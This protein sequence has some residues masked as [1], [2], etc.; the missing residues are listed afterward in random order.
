MNRSVALRA[1]CPARWRGSWP[2]VVGGTMV[3][4]GICL[5]A[6]VL[7]SE[8]SE[9]QGRPRLALYE[10]PDG[11]VYIGMFM[12]LWDSSDQRVGDSRSFAQRYQDVLDNELGR[13]A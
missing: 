3:V 9:A 2:R 6:L 1:L 10:P 11:F 7:G 8:Q 5:I 12:R 13:K 4:L